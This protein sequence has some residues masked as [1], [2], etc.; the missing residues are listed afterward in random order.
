MIEPSDWCS[1]GKSSF[2]M[3]LLLRLLVLL[4]VLLAR[5]E[6]PLFGIFIAWGGFFFLADSFP[7]DDATLLLPA[8]PLQ[9]RDKIQLVIM[10]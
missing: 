9:R 2:G 7:F 3:V 5:L 10:P 1:Y 8:S 4:A 6:S